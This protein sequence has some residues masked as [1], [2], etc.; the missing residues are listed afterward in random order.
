M[1]DPDNTP[2]FIGVEKISDNK[3]KLVHFNEEHSFV[4]ELKTDRNG[5]LEWKNMN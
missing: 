2:N 4:C 1:S 5:K 3:F